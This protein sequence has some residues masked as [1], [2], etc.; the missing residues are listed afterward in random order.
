[1]ETIS[2]RSLHSGASDDYVDIVDVKIFIQLVN[3]LIENESKF[4]KAQV[5]DSLV[6]FE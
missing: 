2:R 5:I 4:S 6:V 1:M 3:N